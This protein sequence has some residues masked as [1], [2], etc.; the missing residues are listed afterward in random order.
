LVAAAAAVNRRTRTNAIAAGSLAVMLAL[1]YFMQREADPTRPLLAD[2]DT[3]AVD[4]VHVAL[5]DGPA[6]VLERTADGWRM[7]APVEREVAV[8]RVDGILRGLAT[9]SRADY[10]ADEVPLADVGLADPRAV[11]T[12]DGH[13]FAFGDRNPVNGLRYVL[14]DGAVYLTDDLVV[15]RLAG[16]PATW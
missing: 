12:V 13:A 4:T 1:A 14:H 15:F 5:R 11:V 9:P 10:P 2:F 6:I 7:T 8:S 3:A 16:D